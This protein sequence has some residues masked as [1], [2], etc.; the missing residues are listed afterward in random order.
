MWTQIKDE[1]N[2][3]DDE[4]LMLLPMT[5]RF[6]RETFNN[7]FLVY[8]TRNLSK[9]DLFCLFVDLV[10]PLGKQNLPSLKEQSRIKN[11]VFNSSFCNGFNSLLFIANK[12]YVRF[13]L[14]N[15]STSELSLFRMYFHLNNKHSL[16]LVCMK[17]DFAKY[18]GIK[19]HQSIWQRV[20][21]LQKHTVPTRY[22]LNVLHFPFPKCQLQYIGWI[23][24]LTCTWCDNVSEEFCCVLC[25]VVVR[26]RICASQQLDTDPG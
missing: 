24:V 9:N 1:H 3:D 20:L 5:K 17:V 14:N 16:Y 2:F 11:T 25:I 4:V 12:P 23:S 10:L 19:S 13:E 7:Q 18:S 8:R 22:V 21:N 15:I 6:R 26:Y